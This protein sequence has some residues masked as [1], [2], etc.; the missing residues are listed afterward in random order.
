[1]PFKDLSEFNLYKKQIEL[2]EKLFDHN[3]TIITKAADTG[4]DYAVALYLTLRALK[5]KKI[6]NSNPY[7]VLI[8][9]PNLGGGEK[10]INYI[11]K[12][13]NNLSIKFKGS[14]S[15]ITLPNA[16]TIEVVS[17]SQY[18]LIGRKANIVYVSNLSYTR[19]AQHIFDNAFAVV[20]LSGQLIISS[21]IKKRG[22][23]FDTLLKDTS[24]DQV[25]YKWSFNP[26]NDADKLMH[27]ID[28]LQFSV[29]C[30][31]IY[32]KYVDSTLK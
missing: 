10:I 16:V 18:A 29:L 31:N 2:V 6:A 27:L 20:G 9:A 30:Q 4:C 23:V 7:N 5:P 1:M 22:D 8:I 32:C 12:F 15:K 25:E 26:N 14:K 24:F 3:N 13:L 11:T 28:N 21:R 19:N 17:S